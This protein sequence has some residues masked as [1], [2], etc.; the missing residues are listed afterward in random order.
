MS[1]FDMNDELIFKAKYLKY[2]NKYINLKIEQEGGLVFDKNTSII[3]YEKSVL[4][5]MEELKRR[6]KEA[7]ESTTDS[8]EYTDETGK[9][10]KIQIEKYLNNPVSISLAEVNGLGNI[11]EYRIGSKEIL[12]RLLLNL[13]LQNLLLN[14][15]DKSHIVTLEELGFKEKEFKGLSKTIADLITKYNKTTIALGVTYTNVNPVTTDNLKTKAEILI[16]LINNNA[17]TDRTTTFSEIKKKF[18]DPFGSSINVKLLPPAIFI[19]YTGD[20]QVKFDNVDSYVIVKNFKVNED[21]GLS[22]QIVSIGSV[23]FEGSAVGTSQ[24]DNTEQS[25]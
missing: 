7:E 11:F 14:D 20:S 6:F 13:K 5:K 19:G 10:Q 9:I 22:F 3:F 2:K 18:I 8:Y 4:P 16:N 21:K 17:S 15:I 24:P 23:I 25:E 1:S 12:P